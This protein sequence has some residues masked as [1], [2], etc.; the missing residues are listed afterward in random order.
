MTAPAPHVN[1][2]TLALAASRL[3]RIEILARAAR[4]AAEGHD[5]PNAAYHSRALPFHV[6]RLCEELAI[7]FNPEAL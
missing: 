4:K 7:P 6:A 2:S 1:A 3:G 5:A